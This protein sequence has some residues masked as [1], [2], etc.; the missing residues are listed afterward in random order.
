MVRF[1]TIEDLERIVEIE[2]SSF[3]SPWSEGSLRYEIEE[4]QLAEVFVIEIN[5]EV[6][7]YMSYM[8]IIDEVHINNIAIDSTKRGYGYGRE[9]VESVLKSFK[10]NYS[11]TLE[12][13]NDNY[14][15]INLYRSLGF[16]QMG[17]RKDYYGKGQDALIM[18]I[19]R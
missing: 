3:D 15:A 11:V 16:E 13:R 17:I 19:R 12:V 9:L 10:G 7:G 8:K 4:N 1:A 14:I 6:V 2:N 5:Q 18:W